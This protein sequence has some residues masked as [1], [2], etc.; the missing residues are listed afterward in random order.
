MTT[1]HVGLPT[2]QGGLARYAKNFDLLEVRPVATSTPRPSKLRQW[3]KEVPPSFVFSVVLP[4]IL[5]ELP[6]PSAEQEQALTTCLEV[7]SALEARCIVLPTPPSVTPTARNKKRLAELLER[8]PRDAVFIGW[9]PRGIWTPEELA[10]WSRELDVHL[11]ADVSQTEAPRG[12]MLYT[13]L[14][15]IGTNTRLSAGILARVRGA[16]AERREVFVV[17]E[18]DGPKRIADALRAPLETSARAVAPTVLRPAMRA[19]DE[20]Q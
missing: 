11:I 15:G 2:H 14:R 12:S 13:R 8:L 17:V 18:A 4:P 7:A 6:L 19:D 10:L 5:G 9:E 16:F 20:E 1:V 3:R